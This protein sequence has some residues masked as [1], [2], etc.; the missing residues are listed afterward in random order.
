M[1]NSRTLEAT[2]VGTPKPARLQ[3]R[4]Q[5]KS[6]PLGKGSGLASMAPNTSATRKWIS[7]VSGSMKDSRWRYDHQV[8][9]AWIPLSMA[10]LGDE[11]ID[12]ILPQTQNTHN[13]SYHSTQPS[14]GVP[15]KRRA[16]IGP[17]SC[18]KSARAHDDYDP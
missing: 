3:A 1:H 18:D 9:S 7:T 6:H 15:C 17:G 4:S 12:Y 10:G 13:V 8:M 11:P 16:R 14:Y 5:T 2:V